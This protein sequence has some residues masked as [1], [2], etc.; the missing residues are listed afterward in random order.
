[1]DLTSSSSADGA[2][3]H[4]PGVIHDVV[5]GAAD[6]ELRVLSGLQT[7]R[8]GRAVG[9]VAG[10]EGRVALRESALDVDPVGIAL[11]GL[12]DGAAVEKAQAAE[13]RHEPARSTSFAERRKFQLDL[14]HL[15]SSVAARIAGLYPPP[16]GE[17]RYL[18]RRGVGGVAV[19]RN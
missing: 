13:P 8:V 4:F 3:L 14:S 12:A 15:G 19:Q 17:D 16:G 5:R 9:V 6:E 1:M 11:I 2:V 10:Q 18:S 7:L